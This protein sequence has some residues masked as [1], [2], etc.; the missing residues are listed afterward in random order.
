MDPTGTKI[1]D[2]LRT[3]PKGNENAIELS[4]LG[5]SDGGKARVVALQNRQLQPEPPIAPDRA[6][7]P[8]RQHIFHDVE[9]FGR[10]LEAYKSKHTVVLADVPNVTIHAVLDE[11]AE[12][13][14]EVVTLQPQTHPLF[15]PWQKLLANEAV[16]ILSFARFVLQHRRSI[17]KP[18][19]LETALLFGQ[20]RA[21]SK[22]TLQKGVGKKSVNGLVVETEIQSDRQAEPVDLPDTLTIR[23]PLY[24]G[25]P[26][27]D[28]EIDLLTAVIADSVAV[29][30]SS[31]HVLEAEV[32]AFAGMVSALGEIEGIVV[33]LGRPEHDSWIYLR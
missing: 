20:V 29:I 1:A 22:V 8:R 5:L 28:L 33:G 21:A 18:D 24:V 13:G 12:N 2:F 10:Y 32:E 3:V 14:F 19:G 7:S 31:S 9:G 23:C 16:D 11:T 4:E 27:V 17:I 15:A 6:E 30:V 26:A 25:T